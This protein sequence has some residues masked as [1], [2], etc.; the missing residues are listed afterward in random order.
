MK[1]YWLFLVILLM[2]S[3]VELFAAS[4]SVDFSSTAYGTISD[5][6]GSSVDPNA[7]LT[8]FRSLLVPMGGRSEAMGTAFT[9]VADDSSFMESNPAGSSQLK[10]TEFS[11]MHN[12]WIADTK[13]ESAIYAVRFNNFGIGVGGKWL[14]LPF[15]EY[16]TFGD[17]V[18]K[19]YYS[20]ATAILNI[21][22]NF[23]SGY[24]FNGVSLGAN[25]KATYR[26]IP[27]YTNVNGVLSVGSGASQS[28]LA[29]MG[30]FGVLTRFNLFKLYASRSRNFAIGAAIKNVG[31][32]V[33]GEPLPTVSSAG[34]SYSPIRPLLLSFD[35]NW[36]INLMNPSL[37]ERFYW[38]SGMS[39]SLAD[40]FAIQ[41]GFL[42]KGSDP[43]F[44]LGA[45]VD[46]S[47]VSF[48]VD[49]TLDLTTQ[50]VP[51]NRISVNA[52]INLGDGGRL[53]EAQKVEDLYLT[54]L[55]EYAKGNIDVAVVY[56]EQA[57]VEDSTF[58]PARE[59]LTAAQN[60]MKLQQRMNEIQKLEQ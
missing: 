55:E 59:S 45:T 36:P 23:F 53:L 52:K 24:Y 56:W 31:P 42:L 29:V 58:D 21:S 22:Y 46:V 4:G 43:R 12:N 34:V 9:A 30:D 51:F 1:N 15:T 26:G 60:T 19:G 38:S 54:G 13:V 50:A 37:S 25:L 3:G 11:V 10:N 14:Y 39:L 47:Q 16:N 57:L 41:A 27:D 5:Y 32:S 8:A 18:S 49:Y 2:I 17:R 44:S 48:I 33:L 20:E 7:G 6:F 40:F 35:G 28:A